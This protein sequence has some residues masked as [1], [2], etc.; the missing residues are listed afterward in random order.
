MGN[1]Q[2]SQV[3]LRS[4]FSPGASPT[5]SRREEFIDAEDASVASD[6]GDASAGAS[7]TIRL[8]PSRASH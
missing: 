8:F 7:Q 5:I 2:L 6:V 3:R 1:D 4:A